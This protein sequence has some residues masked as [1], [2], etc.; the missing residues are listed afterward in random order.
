METSAS[1]DKY[2]GEFVEIMYEVESMDDDVK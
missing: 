1:E 2:D